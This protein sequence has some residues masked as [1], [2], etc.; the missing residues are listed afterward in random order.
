MTDIFVFIGQQ[1]W[2]WK[3]NPQ[4]L[5]PLSEVHYIKAREE[6]S[7]REANTSISLLNKQNETKKSAKWH[8]I[9]YHFEC[10]FWM[11]KYG[12]GFG[13]ETTLWMP[14]FETINNDPPLLFLT[15]LS[16][17][18]AIHLYSCGQNISI[19]HKKYRGFSHG[20][21]KQILLYCFLLSKPLT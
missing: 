5:R 3:F 6:V 2:R 11:M 15:R 19:R 13:L 16:V 14:R 1:C 21:K 7:S 9:V 20:Y 4:I 12:K 17:F 8:W 18:I 10:H